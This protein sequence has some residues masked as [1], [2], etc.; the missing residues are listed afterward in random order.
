MRKDGGH[1]LKKRYGLLLLTAGLLTPAM[2]RAQEPPTLE[3]S[4]RAFGGREGKTYY[5]VSLER[6]GWFLRAT[7]ANKGA[8]VQSGQATVLSGGS[9][10]EIG[11]SLK[12]F[13]GATPMLGVALP[14]TAA[15]N[16]KASLT[17]R[18]RYERGSF[19]VE[20]RAVL[21]RDALVGVTLGATKTSGNL[22]LSG[23]VTPMVSGKNGVG[24]I[25]GLPNRT[26]L[27][28]VGLTRGA[29]T[30]GATN[31]LGTTTGFSLSPSAGGTAL[32]LKVRTSL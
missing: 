6:G 32:V 29:V 26:T 30:L 20:P 21:G 13:R 10:F 11:G 12:P 31:A 15:R 8:S 17:A 23:S 1:P 25:S 2:A 3:L 24:S 28:E 27:W 5:G 19:S 7:G 16:Q 18:L 9:D 14:D 22:T 4:A